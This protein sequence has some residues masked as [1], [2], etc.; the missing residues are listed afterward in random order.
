[1]EKRIY[2][3]RHCEAQGQPPESQ[4]TKQGFMQAIH[5]TEFFSEITIDRIIS[6]PF[7]RAIQS[8]E[9][10]SEKAKLKIEI[11]ERLSER[12]LSTRDLPGWLEKLKT[13]FSDLDLKFEGGESSKEAMK[14]IVNV[15]DEAFE[16]ESENTIIVTHGNL[17]S[18]LLKSYDNSFD[19]NS[20]KRLS[21]P[22]VFVLNYI[23]N[24]VTME[25]L[26]REDL[27]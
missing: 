15:V 2:I 10:M 24:E 13:T 4:L 12:T 26:W 21:N 27:R 18:L 5:L 7:L 14:R 11:D 16:N 17:M 9:P 20:W 22:D 19:F 25:R 8:V 23:N 6:S 3:V 1:M